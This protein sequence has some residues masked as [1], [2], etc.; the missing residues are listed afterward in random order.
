MDDHQEFPCFDRQF[1]DL[2]RF[3]H[4]LVQFHQA[5]KVASWDEL[6]KQVHE[7]FT[8]SRMEQME[9]AVPGWGKMA[10][11]SEGITLVHVACVFLGMYML[12]EFNRLMVRQQQI[13]KWVILF[14]D[15]DK[16]HIRGKKDT[17]HAFRS[18]V[19]AANCLPGLGF[20]ITSQYPV[21]IGPWSQDT[22]Q[23]CIE[24]EGDAPPIPDNRKLSRILSGIEQLYGANAPA[25]L[26]VKTILLH[27]SLDVDEHYPT[28]APL[29]KDEI[30]LHIGPNLLPLLRV[31]MLSDNEGWSLF[32]QETRSRQRT[33]TL[34]AFEKVERLVMQQTLLNLI[35]KDFWVSIA[36]NDFKTPDGYTLEDLTEVLFGYLGSTDPELRDDIAYIVYANWLR[37]EMYPSQVLRVHVDRLLANLNQGIS[38]TGSDTVFLRTFSILWLAEIVHNDNKKP[39]LERDQI[40]R[41]LAKGIW[42]LGAEQDPRGHIPVKGWAHALAHTADLILVL[43]CNRHIEE[44]DL[45]EMLSAISTKIVHSTNHIYIHG[46][47]ERLASAILEILRRDAIPADKVEGWLKSLAEPDGGSWKGAYVEQEKARAYHNTRNL[48][49]S[50][51]LELVSETGS[52]PHGRDLTELVLKCLQVLRP[53]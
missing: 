52:L 38:E 19:V 49:R 47:D 33:D 26:I 18:A 5:G 43:A 4:S 30:K 39:V 28:P 36:K 41:I 20:P 6:E 21:L 15:I 37:R 51:Y 27:I 25:A 32:H 16:S 2:N 11:Y 17:L 40:K 22:S 50:V 10:S 35:D 53:Y 31:M 44:A 13:M 7:F 42:Y 48:L 14:H 8:P 3:I 12:P 45:W 34:A 29:T 23:A 1:S 46:E 9:S 24:G